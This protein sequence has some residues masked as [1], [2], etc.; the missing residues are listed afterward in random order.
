MKA[1]LSGSSAILLNCE[2]AKVAY[3]V[4]R[5]LCGCLYVCV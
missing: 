4:S 5:G 3:E 2:V 1:L